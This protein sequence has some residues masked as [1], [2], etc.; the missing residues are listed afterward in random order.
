M[1]QHLNMQDPSRR[2]VVGG[3]QPQNQSTAMRGNAKTKNMVKKELLKRHESPR[4]RRQ[5]INNLAGPQSYTRQGGANQ[6]LAGPQ[7]AQNL[8]NQFSS[9]SNTNQSF[10]GASPNDMT[11]FDSKIFANGNLKSGHS[12]QSVGGNHNKVMGSGF[13]G[14]MK[15][16]NMS[17]DGASQ[18]FNRTGPIKLPHKSKQHGNASQNQSQ[19]VEDMFHVDDS[20]APTKDSNQR[21]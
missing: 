13:Q 11:F 21:Q 15:F 17:A 16:Q 19:H 1:N 6:F 4:S 2:R 20:S 10:S 3:S 14:G 7:N 5:L 9:N 18:F 8:I 12:S